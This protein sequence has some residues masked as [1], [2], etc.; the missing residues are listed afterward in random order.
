MTNI[1]DVTAAVKLW[2]SAD[3]KRKLFALEV[4]PA[5]LDHTEGQVKEIADKIGYSP[6]L[7]YQYARAGRLFEA[8]KQDDGER[9][10]R[11]WDMLN[12]SIFT[13]LADRWNAGSMTIEQVWE[14]TLR[15]MDEHL[16]VEAFRGLVPSG[17]KARI[18]ILRKLWHIVTYVEKFIFKAETFGLNCD[19]REYA[20]LIQQLTDVTETIKRIAPSDGDHRKA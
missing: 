8:L 17:E 14:W 19:Q 18:G 20:K 2:Q 4:A 5:G 1:I 13:L 10:E 16:T 6:S 7:V 15:V 3:D 9:A 12:V 11:V